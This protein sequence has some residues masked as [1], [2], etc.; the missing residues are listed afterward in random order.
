MRKR[1][2]RRFDTLAEGQTRQP[3]EE[4]AMLANE[5]VG[6]FRTG[7]NQARRL[8]DLLPPQGFKDCACA[9]GDGPVGPDQLDRFGERLRGDLG[10]AIP[11]L[12]RRSE[13]D[14]VARQPLPI[15]DPDA[16]EAAPAVEYKKW[17]QATSFY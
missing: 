10:K 17:L 3:V 2:A 11:D 12:L 13:I 6:C 8:V 1:E 15:V 7:R 16:A 4:T 14:P 9:A 5:S